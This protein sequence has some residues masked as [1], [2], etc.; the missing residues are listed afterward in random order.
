MPINPPRQYVFVLAVEVSL[1][2]LQ[3]IRLAST[4]DAC[5]TYYFTRGKDM[6]EN[7]V[8]RGHVI[9]NLTAPEPLFCFK[10]CRLECRC[11]SFNF[12]QST[13]Q[14]N[15]QLNEENR[16]TSFGALEFAEGWQYYDLVIEYSIRPNAPAVGCQN[17][18]CESNP[19][20]NGGTCHE[21]CDVIGKRFNCECGPHS[22]GKLCEAKTCTTPDWLYYNNSCFKVFTEEVPWFDARKSCTTIGS[23]LISIHSTEEN[24]FVQQEK[25]LISKSSAWIGLFNLNSTDR[26]YEWVDGSMVD[27]RNWGD[28]EPNNDNSGENCTELYRVNGKWND[29]SCYANRTYVCGKKFSP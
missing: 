21:T 23:N 28:G 7:H 27:F 5:M 29:E 4:G 16:Y 10:A 9:A 2:L 6:I 20:L 3:I 25:S 26:S 11:I 14:D 1:H 15:C 17:G 19:C 24:N 12:K 18:C 13:H 22:Y 8:L